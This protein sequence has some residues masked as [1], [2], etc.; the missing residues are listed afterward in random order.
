MT[1][2]EIK[3]KLP[4][5]DFINLD[6]EM[7]QDVSKKIGSDCYIYQ[8]SGMYTFICE[9]KEYLRFSTNK[10]VEIYAYMCVILNF[11]IK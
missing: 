6:A 11:K 4:Q 7:I 3:L 5:G 1:K 8:E 9:D 10:K 2:Q